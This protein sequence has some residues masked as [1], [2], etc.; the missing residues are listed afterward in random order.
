MQG[1]TNRVEEVLVSLTI[2]VLGAGNG[3]L[4]AA[5]DLTLRGHEVRLF[6]R[7]PETLDPIIARGGIQ[8]EGLAGNGFAAVPIATNKL[9]EAVEGADLIMLA[10]PVTAH[11][12]YART[13][14]PVLESDQPVFLNPG[15]TC[16]GLHFASELQRAG[17]PGEIRTCE[18]ST[19]TYACRI[20]EPGRVKVFSVVH[21]I[22]FAVF[23]GKHLHTL[24]HL[25]KQIYPAIRPANNV[26]ET[27]FLNINAVEHPPMTLLN[28]GWIEYTKGDFNIYYEGTT[29][30]VC[31]VIDA[32]DL[33]RMALAKALGL[34]TRSFVEMFFEAGY[35]TQHAVEVG[36]AYQ[37][38]QESA[39]NRWIKGPA[40]LDH[41]YVHED[42]GFGLVPWS[43]FGRL[44]GVDT[45]V[46]NYLI[47]LA[48]AMN[49]RD[50]AREGLTLEKLGLSNLVP[51]QL[52]SYLYEGIG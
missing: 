45:P 48:S 15:H 43:N 4:A 35:T 26:L 39:P 49:Q 12:Y 6:T 16:G 30:S 27:A 17:Y 18:V 37:A 29:P 13:L 25:I 50:Y 31:R 11:E 2:A 41:R 52:D 44:L 36:T 38:L 34:P 33:E 28:A 8:L 23:P 40:S 14:A 9:V 5:A 20:Q 3:G 51:G 42:I 7:S 10:V 47:R 19:L 1:V 24:Y 32:V 46:I 22:P 21:D